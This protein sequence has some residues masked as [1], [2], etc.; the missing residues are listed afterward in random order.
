MRIPRSRIIHINKCMHTTKQSRTKQKVRNL[1]DLVTLLRTY[2][3]ENNTLYIGTMGLIRFSSKIKQSHVVE[4][5]PESVHECQSTHQSSEI[6]K[7]AE[8]REKRQ[9]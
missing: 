7:K 4:N 1:S 9:E 2:L 5:V 3:G 6:S 8:H